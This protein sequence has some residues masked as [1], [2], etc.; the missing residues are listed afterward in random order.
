MCEIEIGTDEVEVVKT[1]HEVSSGADTVAVRE[2]D[3][4]EL[5]VN[6]REF[7]LVDDGLYVGVSSEK[8]PQWLTDIID[9]VVDDVVG[10]KLGQ[11][12][13]AINAINTSLLELEVAKN[14][15][16]VLINI[17]QT[18]DGV[19]ASKLE[20]LNATVQQNTANIINIDVAKATPEEALALSIEHLNAQINDG[21][22]YALVTDLETAIANGDMANAT[23]ITSLEAQHGANFSTVETILSSSAGPYNVSANAIVDLAG[24]IVDDNGVLRATGGVIDALKTEIAD[25]TIK[26][27]DVTELQ[28]YLNDPAAPWVG[29]SS[30]LTNQLGVT[31]NNV[32][33]EFRYDS[34]LVF[35]GKSYNTGFG[36]ANEVATGQNDSNGVPIWN[37]EFW[38]NADKLKFTNSNQTGQT[39]PFTIDASGT[40]P[41]VTFNGKVSFTN[42]PTIAQADDIPT[43][44]AELTDSANYDNANAV[45]E[46]KSYI[47]TVITEIIFPDVPTT[48]TSS[49][50]PSGSAVNGSIWRQTSGTTLDGNTIPTGQVMHYQY[51]GSSW[52]QIGGTYIDGSNIIT[53]TLDASQVSVTNLN[54]NSIT[55]GTLDAG[56]ITVNNLNADNITS[57]SLSKAEVTTGVSTD[58]I[59]ESDYSNGNFHYVYHGCKEVN[60]GQTLTLVETHR[61]SYQDENLNTSR[62]QVNLVCVYSAYAVPPSN[63][64]LGVD[65]GIGIGIGGFVAVNAR[66]LIG[67][68]AGNSAN[69]YIHVFV[70]FASDN[71]SEP[72]GSTNFSSRLVWVRS[73]DRW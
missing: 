56:S 29:G 44:V 65:G 48:I 71:I 34:N 67:T 31:E 5:T 69:K 54:A 25:G 17:E 16:Q 50:P 11:L 60:T 45:Q 58:E 7:C 24:T 32:K 70:K 3:D 22:I 61:M 12:S 9:T 53:G 18:I 28:G 21:D 46:A 2:S 72:A 26:L 1:A 62:L 36:L 64:E 35:D 4:L 14:Q 43:T 23:S 6:K 63:G 39:A 20:T 73:K 42:N 19:V 8:T 27:S 55:S 41:Q 68:L 13:D 15:Y 40:T 59:G 52:K 38:I 10:D 57:G 37:S 30:T 33:S 51:D 66:S 47:D 49:N